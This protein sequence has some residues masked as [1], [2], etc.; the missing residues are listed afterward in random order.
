MES[1]KAEFIS[2]LPVQNGRI[3]LW[4]VKCPHC[5]PLSKAGANKNLGVRIANQHNA[6]KHKGEMLLKIFQAKRRKTRG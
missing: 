1:P 3:E 4:T 5:G 6:E 2:V